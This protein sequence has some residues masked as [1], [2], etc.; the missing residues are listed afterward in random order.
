[1]LI[2]K[3]NKSVIL[4]YLGIGIAI[5]GMYLAMIGQMNMAICCLIVC[6]ICD[7]FD[8]KIARMCRRTREEEEFGIQIDSLADVVNFIALP[9]VIATCLGANQWYDI[10]AFGVFAICGVAR[11]A[12]F[13]ISVEKEPASEPIKYYIG[14]P[15]TYVALMMPLF[16]LMIKWFHCQNV[17]LYYPLLMLALSFF[18]LWNR[19]IKKPKGV[20]YVIF[21][22][23]AI[24]S[25]IAYIFFV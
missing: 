23:M 24:L 8:G 10:L 1:M 9:I 12:F 7:L 19:K 2:G 17:H 22:V 18:F 14:L 6:G 4:T 25:I 5:V 16:E 13:N 15:V 11:L 3:W 20:A 21:G